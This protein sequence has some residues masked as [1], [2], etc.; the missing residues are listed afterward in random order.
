MTNLQNILKQAQD[1]SQVSKMQAELGERRIE[2]SAGGGMVTA[3]VNGR[4]ELLSLRIDPQVVDPGDVEMLEDLVVG[5]GLR[6]AG[7]RGEMANER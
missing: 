4:Q 6:G 7:S 2:A 1:P 5:S 3:V